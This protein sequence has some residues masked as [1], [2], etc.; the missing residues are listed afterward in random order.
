MRVL[1]LATVFFCL[2]LSGAQ[3]EKVGVSP[4]QKIVELLDGCAAKTQKDLDAESK[5][6]EKYTQFCDDEVNDR[7]YAIETSDRQLEDIGAT[8]E[9][10]T[11]KIASLEEEGTDLGTTISDKNQELDKAITTRDG[12]HKTF[13]AA[14]KELLTSI[15]QLDRGITALKEG[16]AFFLQGKGQSLLQAA[17]QGLSAIINAESVDAGDKE[18]LQSFLETPKPTEGQMKV[19]GSDDDDD[20]PDSRELALMQAMMHQPQAT[21]KN[22]E[23]Q[24]GG[25][26]ET[27]TEMLDKAEK[28]L[29]DAR[30]KEMEDAH[31]FALTKQGLENEIA[32]NTEKK[33]TANNNKAQGE[34]D[35]EEATL[36]KV[37]ADKTKA[38]DVDY[39]GTLKT[40]CQ[41]KSV[42]WE[43]RLRSANG[44]LAAIA[45]AKEILQSGVKVLLQIRSSTRRNLES[46]APMRK[47]LVESMRGLASQHRSFALNQILIAASKDPFQK[48]RDMINKMLDKLNKE[49]EA[50]ATKEAF[51]QEEMGKSKKEHEDKS[52]KL[53]KH[54][55]RMDAAGTTIAEL[56]EGIK[57]LEAE[58][59]STAKAEKEA[60]ELRNEE[61]AQFLTASGDYR[62]AAEAVA[63]AI[64]VLKNY[65]EGALFLQ[66]SAETSLSQRVSGA[67]RQPSF[68][69][70]QASAGGTIISILEM[71][72]EDFTNMLAEL[73]TT[74]SEAAK[75]YEK[76][77]NEN[78]VANATK[79]MEVKGKES[80]V[81]SLKVQLEHSTED[82]ESISGELDAVT[83]YMDKLKP[84][85]EQKVETYEEKKARREAE[86][87]GLKNGL[88]ILGGDG[89]AA[90]AS[91]FV[92]LA[93]T[94]TR[95]L[96]AR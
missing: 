96:R 92:Q 89:L 6:M 54:K 49:A 12:E 8:I 33:S 4:V 13:V 2:A 70:N 61:H 30:K 14:E 75:V 95:S 88:A 42:E 18:K 62:Q 78:E 28:A 51:C 72:Q 35:L 50:A 36:R 67:A 52:A 60:T 71:A 27:M 17:T 91:S 15:D 47:Q 82:Y 83:A 85:C 32:H 73:E 93:A 94:S 38:A 22:F 41:Q 5:V 69:G 11:A 24:G 59:A 43:E 86:I 31:A 79:E 68:A 39:M 26:I 66:V 9:D 55:T 44:E 29:S 3:A 57:S 64:E 23:S 87:E 25:I 37:D 19:S 80:E 53:E 46:E 1:A 90:G 48:V 21:Q 65:Y 81:K 20:A 40:E 77:T 63:S 74:E 45:K 34:R 10:T 56:T 84:E 58:L 76:M 7:T 16:Q